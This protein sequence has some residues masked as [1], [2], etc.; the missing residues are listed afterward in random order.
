MTPLCAMFWSQT[1]PIF[2]FALKKKIITGT[3]FENGN[4][5][6]FFFG[7]RGSPGLSCGDEDSLSTLRFT[8]MNLNKQSKLFSQGH[9]PIQ[10]VVPLPHT[11]HAFG[12]DKNALR[13]AY[14]QQW[15]RIRDKPTYWTISNEQNSGKT[16]PK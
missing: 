12:K 2:R 11:I 10:L 7:F 4:R 9:S 14:P 3:E 1:E 15:E 13:Q 5:T 8:V 16:S 6:W